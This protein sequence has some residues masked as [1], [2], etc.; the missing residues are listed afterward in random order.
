MGPWDYEEPERRW[1]R[2][3]WLGLLAL[4][5]FAVSFVS[6]VLIFNAADE[7]SEA[8]AGEPSEAAAEAAEAEAAEAETAEGNEGAE[9]TD[10]AED[11]TSSEDDEAEDAGAQTAGSAM[12]PA[13]EIDGPF[14]DATLNLD[15]GP[16]PGLFTLSGR[17]PNEELASALIQSAE[18]SYAPFVESDIEV[19]PTMEEAPWLANAPILIGLLPSITD[20]TIRLVDG[21]VHLAAR[22]PNPEYLAQFQGALDFLTDMPVEIVD[23]NITDLEPP[24]FYADV[25]DGKIN[26]SGFVPSEE[27]RQILEGGA[28]AA[29]GPENVTSELTIDEG[30]Y[31]SFWMYTMPGVFQLFTPFPQ[32]QIQ[33]VD[34]FSSGALQGGV[35][36]AV[37]STEITEEAAQ[38]LNIGAS[39]LARDLSLFMT[40]EGHTDSSG[41]DDYNLA[42]SEA[43]A[44]SVVA[45]LE[46]AGIDPQRL[47]AVGAGETEPLASN[48]TDEGKALNRRVE[49]IFGPPP[50]G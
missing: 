38:V 7:T 33:V 6:F 5:L 27:I 25:E 47:R 26:L 8:S 3:V 36:F 46:A 24:A 11:A 39:I 32:Y 41:P 45:Y 14:V 43:R 1:T 4:G 35:N 44:K 17:V 12:T 23:Q 30:T 37:D 49:F 34:G 48:D 16:G 20:G 21:E 22:S 10:D 50:S 28:A 31:I 9:A 2:P 18:L 40:V 19:D 29:Y 15:A 13:E 42:L